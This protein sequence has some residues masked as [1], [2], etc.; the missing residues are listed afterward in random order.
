MLASDPTTYGDTEVPKARPL[1]LAAMLCGVLCAASW[2]A[3]GASFG[4]PIGPYAPLPPA[5]EGGTPELVFSPEGLLSGFH[6]WRAGLKDYGIT[7]SVHER[8]E[9]WANLTGGGS[10]SGASYNGL[11]TGKLDVDLDKLA[12]WSGGE[13]F[14]LWVRHSRP[15]PVAQPSR[16]T[17]SSSAISRRPPP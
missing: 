6:R 16:Q 9:V 14:R 5:E 15:W 3:R 8:S 13:F 12:G 11:T 2:Q 17:S 7:F 4:L 10:F 1:V